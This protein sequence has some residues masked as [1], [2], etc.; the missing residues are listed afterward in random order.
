MRKKIIYIIASLLMLYL[1]GVFSG[2]FRY[3]GKYFLNFDNQVREFLIDLQTPFWNG[4]FNI[5]T[6]FGEVKG[7]IGLGVALLGIFL[8]YK[9]R[10]FLLLFIMTIIGTEA[11]IWIGKVFT[12]RIRPTGE[13][14]YLEECSFPSNHAAIALAFY[15]FVIILM[16]NERLTKNNKNS[17]KINFIALSI[18]FC[19]LLIVLIGF[20]RI[21]LG[22]HFLSDVIMGYI[23]AGLWLILAKNIY[24]KNILNF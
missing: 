17:K 20:S 4:F 9:K 16:N 23:V 3:L 2:L 12:S 1:I 18:V 11:F 24:N 8:F 21:Y 6:L 22:A 19:S 14:C 10:D 7:F 5:I 15:G 13:E